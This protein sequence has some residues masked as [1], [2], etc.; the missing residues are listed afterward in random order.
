MDSNITQ[1]VLLNTWED[2][3]FAW[4]TIQVSHGVLI[5]KVDKGV[6]SKTE[7]LWKDEPNLIFSAFLVQIDKFCLSVVGMCDADEVVVQYS[8]LGKLI[9]MSDLT[10]LV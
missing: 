3:L 2:E 4:L 9:N 1:F 8:F 10:V 6:A 5:T 7:I